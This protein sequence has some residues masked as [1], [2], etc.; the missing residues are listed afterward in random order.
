MVKEEI[1]NIKIEKKAD[2]KD[3]RLSEQKSKKKKLTSKEQITILEIEKAELQDKYVRAAAE[4]E[5]FRKR[6]IAEKSDWI[7][8]R[9]PAFGA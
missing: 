1:K 4:F 6:N 5:N 7:K 2:E 3:E 8:K 9:Y